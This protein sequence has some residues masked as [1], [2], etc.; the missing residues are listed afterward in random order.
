[1]LEVPISVHGEASGTVYLRG[2]KSLKG[3]GRIIVCFFN[4]AGK[5]SGRTLS[6]SDGYFSFLGLPPG[7]YRARIDTTQLRRVNMES[8]PESI[9]FEIMSNADGDVVDGLEFVLKSLNPVTGEV[10]KPENKAVQ[11]I[12]SSSKVEQAVTIPIAKT[13][14]LKSI[15]PEAKPV[16]T[17]PEPGK[18]IEQPQEKDING[19]ENKA[20]PADVNAVKAKPSLKQISANPSVG[21]GEPGIDLLTV[22]PLDKVKKPLPGS[23]GIQVGAFSNLKNAELSRSRLVDALAKEVYIQESN[24]IYKVIVTGFEERSKAV[25]FLP[26]VKSRGFVESF[27]VKFK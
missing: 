14:S 3:Q 7:Q 9:P 18:G 26:N 24:G 13:E 21:E 10:I 11:E 27:V 15:T 4:E 12:P 8:S 25:A 19:Q 5:L 23:F 17:K 16:T 2:A 6:E 22:K 20:K 1:L